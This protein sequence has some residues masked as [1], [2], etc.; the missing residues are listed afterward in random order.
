MYATR[1]DLVARFTEAEIASL[2]TDET[3]TPNTD[4]SAAALADASA[5]A[6]SSIAVKYKLPLPNTP[7]V[8]LIAVCDMARY[9]LYKDRPTEEVRKRYDDALNW[10]KRVASDSAKLPFPTLSDEQTKAARNSASLPTGVSYNG[11]V[12]G[13]V[14]TDKML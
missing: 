6:D 5:K 1:E 10:L 9:H 2:E 8:L 14:M 13:S 7:P 11:G 4:F 3:G 12:F